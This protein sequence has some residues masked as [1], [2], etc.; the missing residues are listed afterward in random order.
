MLHEVLVIIGMEVI[1]LVSIAA[2]TFHRKRTDVLSGRY[3][4]ND[5]SNEVMP[6]VAGTE[7]IA[8][9]KEC[10]GSARQKA[11]TTSAPSL[12]T[13]T[14]S[15]VGVVALLHSRRYSRPSLGAGGSNLGLVTRAIDEG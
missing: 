11:R 8:R 6:E 2:M 12:R 9:Q 14:R 3:F 13:D 1:L 5:Q 10:A 7:R 4:G 15:K